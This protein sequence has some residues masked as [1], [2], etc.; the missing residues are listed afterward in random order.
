MEIHFFFHFCV[1]TF[2]IFIYMF[3]VNDSTL[4]DPK[5]LHE[6]IFLDSLI[7]QHPM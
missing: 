3:R 6:I 5:H 1:Q 2:T 4:L 7:A